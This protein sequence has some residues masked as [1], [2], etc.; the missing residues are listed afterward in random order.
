MAV[1]VNTIHSAPEAPHATV[2]PTC[3]PGGQV[4]HQEKPPHRHHR[5]DRPRTFSSSGTV[6]IIVALVVS[7]L[8]DLARVAE[9]FAQ[10]RRRLRPPAVPAG[11]LT[12]QR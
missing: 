8:P 4:H 6:A 3:P 10:L 9:A 11:R 5:A 1:N 12:L 7:L 2:R